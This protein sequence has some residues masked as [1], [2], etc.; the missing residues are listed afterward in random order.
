M[1]GNDGVLP[2]HTGCLPTHMME[3]YVS[4]M[5]VL[6]LVILLLLIGVVPKEGR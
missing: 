5:V 6:R 2:Q 1:T 3:Q 4:I